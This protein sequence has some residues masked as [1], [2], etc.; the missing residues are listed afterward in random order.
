MYAHITSGLSFVT[1]NN[2]LTDAKRIEEGSKD[3][4]KVLENGEYHIKV[5]KFLEWESLLMSCNLF[6]KCLR[7]RTVIPEYLGLLDKGKEL[8]VDSM[9]IIKFMRRQRMHGIG[10]LF[11]MSRRYRIA[12]SNRAMR[13]P[14]KD[15]LEI[16]RAEDKWEQIE[17]ITRR[18]IFMVALHKKFKLL[19][20]PY[21]DDILTSPTRKRA[22]SL[23]RTDSTVEKLDEEPSRSY[24]TR[25]TKEPLNNSTKNE[26]KMSRKIIPTS[27]APM[28]STLMLKYSS[29]T[30]FGKRHKR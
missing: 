16:F 13:K 29:D 20:K 2:L 5:S 10:L 17:D 4:V 22:N 28:N 7:K 9:D 24:N 19:S 12:A 23:T 15:G 1:S 3:K 18:D 25:F 11:S 27:L 6:S 30:E 26:F 14:L 21:G 8:H